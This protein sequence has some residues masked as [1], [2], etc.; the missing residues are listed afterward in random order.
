MSDQA[1][2]N[3]RQTILYLAAQAVHE[4]NRAYCKACADESQVSW[5][6]APDWQKKAS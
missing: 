2:W 4:A 6:E 3:M 5:D 1:Y